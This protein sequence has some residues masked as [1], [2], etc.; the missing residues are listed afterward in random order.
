MSP[1]PTP[2]TAP[3]HRVPARRQPLATSRPRPATAS[4]P[5]RRLKAL[6]VST[7]FLFH[8]CFRI[9]KNCFISNKTHFRNS[10]SSRPCVES[11]RREFVASLKEHTLSRLSRWVLSGKSSSTKLF[12]EAWGS[13]C[14]RKPTRQHE[15]EENP[16]KRRFTSKSF[17]SHLGT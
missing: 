13:V 1:A 3:A 8:P 17:R 2:L 10:S 15:L 6:Y 11:S 4:A 9:E 12:V 16:A 7:G 14:R 5:S